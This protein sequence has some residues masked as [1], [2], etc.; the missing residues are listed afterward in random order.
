MNILFVRFFVFAVFH[1]ATSACLGQQAILSGGG[2][3]AGPGG[4]IAFSIG[5]S[6]Y[7]SFSGTGGTITLGVQQPDL[8]IIIGTQ[9]EE[10]YK[11]SAFP[12]PTQKEI[13]LS[14][15]DLPAGQV[16]AFLVDMNGKKLQ[17][18]PL[19]DV[20]HI[21][22]MD[23]YPPASYLLMIKK[24]DTVVKTFTIIKSN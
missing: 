12:N 6:V 14:A 16:T 8:A 10:D 21:I 3:G 13:Y 7:E 11:L 2:D 15:S 17:E 9:K 19:N 24:D 18:Q 1:L 5:Q 20:L 22:K 4:H 23:A